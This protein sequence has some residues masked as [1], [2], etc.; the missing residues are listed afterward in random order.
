[1]AQ[2]EITIEKIA[3]YLEGADAQGR[4][5]NQPVQDLYIGKAIV[6]AL[7]LISQELDQIGDCLAVLAKLKEPGDAEIT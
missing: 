5:F 2:P 4:N 3:H 6:S 7:L 1:V